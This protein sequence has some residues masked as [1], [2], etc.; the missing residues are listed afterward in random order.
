MMLYNE[1]FAVSSD[2]WEGVTETWD[3]VKGHIYYL[4]EEPRVRG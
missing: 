3:S 2:I 1:G 4:Y